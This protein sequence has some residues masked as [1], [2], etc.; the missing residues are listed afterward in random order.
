MY[1]PW[2]KIWMRLQNR[3]S[4]ILTVLAIYCS[5]GALLGL[6]GLA[7][8]H[9]GLGTVVLLVAGSVGVLG[10]AGYLT[11]GTC[12]RRGTGAVSSIRLRSVGDA[13][14]FATP[15]TASI[16]ATTGY[17][18]LAVTMLL[19]PWLVASM[20]VSGSWQDARMRSVAPMVGIAGAVLLGWVLG[21]VVAKRR[22]L[23]VGLSPEGVYHWAWHGCCFYAWDWVVGIQPFLRGGAL[24]R[25]DVVEP[26]VRSGNAEENWMAQ[27]RSY[28]RKCTKLAASALTVNPGAAYIALVF[29]HR[30]PELR[31]ELG[32]EKA[33]TRI[34]KMDFPDLVR[35]LE[36][37]GLLRPRPDRP[38][39]RE[40]E[41]EDP[42]S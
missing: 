5:G 12:A 27:S 28:R 3:G 41:V 24:V 30:H 1:V 38:R 4:L 18:F 40:R 19:Y 29:Y 25:L 17:V 6:G 20:P 16:V 39:A 26:N 36:T 15:R 9:P 7:S 31:D 10:M 13:T 14:Y 2:P 22:E 35:E 21:R 34:Q 11:A 32:G 37:T 42:R 8:G 23:G 33:V